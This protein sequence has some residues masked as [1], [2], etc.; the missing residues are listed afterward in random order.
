MG[1]KT[2]FKGVLKGGLY[3]PRGRREIFNPPNKRGEGH[4]VGKI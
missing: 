3:Y 4:V 2:S 1:A